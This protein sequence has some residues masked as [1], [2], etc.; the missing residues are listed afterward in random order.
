MENAAIGFRVKSGWAVA[1]LIAESGKVPRVIDRR[2][3][4]LADPG[5]SD[6]TQ[7]FHAGLDLPK[8]S[9]AKIIARLVKRNALNKLVRRD[10]GPLLTP[11]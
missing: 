9:A 7:P 1:V 6:S 5:V 4:E 3:V 10:T 2:R 8:A 11:A